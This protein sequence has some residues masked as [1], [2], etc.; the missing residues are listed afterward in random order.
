VYSL[1][2]RYEKSIPTRLVGP[3]RLFKNSS[4][5][6]VDFSTP[7]NSPMLPGIADPDSEFFRIRVGIQGQGTGPARPADSDQ[8]CR[9]EPK[10]F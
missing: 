6:Y 4:T 8:E 5:E 9:L 10:L 1:A 2:A 7:D 3:H